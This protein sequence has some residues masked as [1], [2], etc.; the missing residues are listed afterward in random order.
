ME[1]IKFFQLLSDF[2]QKELKNWHKFMHSPFFQQ[3]TKVILLSDFLVEKLRK[4]QVLNKEE[5]FQQ[6]FPAQTYDDQKMRL[7]ISYAFRATEQYLAL[8]NWLASKDKVAVHLVDAYKERVDARKFEKILQKIKHK[9]QQQSIQNAAYLWNS[10]EIQKDIGSKRLVC[11]LRM[12]RCIK[13]N[14]I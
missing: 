2:S 1:N 6:L 3:N 11:K 14:M 7:L 12:S 10:F 5:V 8:T 9:R 4:K 13:P